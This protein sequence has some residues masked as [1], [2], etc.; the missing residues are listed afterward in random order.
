ML[1][2]LRMLNSYKSFLKKI[3]P[4]H[5]RQE[6][7]RLERRIIGL[8]RRY[9]HL[10]TEQVF[11]T[12][13]KNGV[14]GKNEQGLSISGAGSHTD[15]IVLP[16]V[17]ALKKI[18]NEYSLDSAVDLGCGDFAVGSKIFDVFDRYT[19]CD[20]SS[21]IV[22]RNRKL[23]DGKN[24]EF[25]KINLAEDDLPFGDIAFVR[26]VLQHLSNREIASFV[27][28]IHFSK[29]YKYIVVTEHLPLSSDFT[30]N[31]DK[32]SGPDIRVSLNSG[33]ILHAPPFSL[34]YK[35][36]YEICSV[37]LDFGRRTSVIKS[38]L[39]IL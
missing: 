26:Q 11:E 15:R 10:S 32:P 35:K 2:I 18:N 14:W 22:D 31:I 17:D 5:F 34:R 20:I 4:L 9:K 28:K 6:I 36:K 19:A 39:Y 1:T 29:P 13:Y 33:V 25:K 23:Y 27:E 24:L 37:E 21:T 16:Y 38:I 30:P 8:E 7:R 12:I 3:I